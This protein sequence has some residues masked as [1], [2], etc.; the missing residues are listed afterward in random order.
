MYVRQT[1]SRRL[2][3]LPFWLFANSGG[4]DDETV[5]TAFER[6]TS[7][8]A[9]EKFCGETATYMVYISE[10]LMARDCNRR[11]RSA[12]RTLPRFSRYIPKPLLAPS[13]H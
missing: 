8:L 2:W 1:V 5:A 11:S 7:D 6:G 12:S 4:L 10:T 9:A 3:R 13:G